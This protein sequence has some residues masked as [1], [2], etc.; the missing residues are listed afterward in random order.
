[1][2]TFGHRIREA[3]K[4]AGL[5]QDAVA[6]AAEI[7]R[8]SISQW[9]SDSTEPD[10]ARIATIASYLGVDRGWLAFG[11]YA[12]GNRRTK[13]RHPITPI[14]EY[15]VVT[16]R[17]PD[18]ITRDDLAVSDWGFPTAWLHNEVHADPRELV[19]MRV[20]GDSM[21]PTLAPGDRVLLDMSRRAPSPPGLFLVWDGI[22]MVVKRVEVVPNS[23]PPRLLLTA[24]NPAYQAYERNLE[25]VEI[26]GRIVA[27]W[28]RL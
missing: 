8:N 4:A 13:A 25:E 27:R 6:A 28:Q 7:T 14:T 20:D 21:V 3:R 26:R 11:D 16:H 2:T 18:D 1:M 12:T 19:M 22:G 10:L 15:D 9:E 23:A 17:A 24:D 5:S